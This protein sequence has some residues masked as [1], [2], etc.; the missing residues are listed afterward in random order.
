MEIEKKG[1]RCPNGY[2][3]KKNDKTK[4]VK[5]GTKKMRHNSSAETNSSKYTTP[6]QS[7]SI[8]TRKF[9]PPSK[10]LRAYNT[11]GFA[12]EDKNVLTPKKS[13]RKRGTGNPWI[14]HVKQYAASHGVNYRE[15]LKD[16]KCK[17]A[18]KK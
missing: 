5:K 11:K 8:K 3:A 2:I 10:E 16:P 4:C 7:P 15:A 1:K 14:A 9:T 18:Y 17:A 6:K 13:T 12:A